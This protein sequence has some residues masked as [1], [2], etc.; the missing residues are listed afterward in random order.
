[1]TRSRT[2]PALGAAVAL[3]AAAAA[4]AHEVSGPLPGDLRVRGGELVATLDVGVAFPPDLEHQLSN[5]LTNIIAVHVSLVPAGDEAP[6]SVWAREVDV[7][8]DVWEETYGVTVKDPSRPRGERLVFR[9]WPALRAFLAEAREV[10]LAPAASLGSGKWVVVTRLELN[11]V[12][13]ELLDRTRELI[14]NPAAGSRVGGSSRSVLGAMASYLLRRADPGS[15]VHVFR[16]RP[17]TVRDGVV[18]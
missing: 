8:Y 12:S 11:P 4:A 6:S 7:L 17:F 2:L 15:D 9:T 13:Q 10:D 5:G 18:R 14:A 1:M 16:T 3:G